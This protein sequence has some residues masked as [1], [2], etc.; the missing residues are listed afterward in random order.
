MV[1]AVTNETNQATEE[2]ARIVKE[3]R[4]VYADAVAPCDT[5]EAW[6]KA[7][8]K[9]QLNW[10]AEHRISL[11]DAARCYAAIKEGYNAFQ[12]NMIANLQRAFPDCGIEVTPAREYSVAIYLH[13][14]DKQQLRQR[15]EK[16]VH[17]EFDAD[18]VSWQGDGA[19]RVWWD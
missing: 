2:A 17:A 1:N 19:L 11:K 13:V 6:I 14:P 10:R 5:E 4:T 12:P 18:T 15:V 16:F 9:R 8:A 7:S 3:F